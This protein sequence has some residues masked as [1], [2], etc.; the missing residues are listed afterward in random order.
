MHRKPADHKGNI[1]RGEA[2]A[3]QALDRVQVAFG[4]GDDGWPGAAETNAQKVGMFQRERRFETGHDFRS[5]RLVYSVVKSLAEKSEIAALKRL[6]EQRDTLQVEDGVFAR[7]GFRQDVAGRR[8]G[9]R[10]L[11][12]Q[13]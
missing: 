8:G 4:E 9:E 5:K 2:V 3:Q 7:D 13:N 1:V 11:G 12:R 6:Q 10:E